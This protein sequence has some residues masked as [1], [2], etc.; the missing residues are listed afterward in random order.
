MTYTVAMAEHPRRFEPDTSVTEVVAHLR[1]WGYAI[2]T[3]VASDEQLDRLADE[4]EPERTA[5]RAKLAA[6]FDKLADAFETLRML[7][8]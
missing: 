4:R 8:P 3:D 2:V 5:R 6:C 1:R 7:R